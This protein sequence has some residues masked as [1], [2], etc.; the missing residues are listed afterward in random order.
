M[1][2]SAFSGGPSLLVPV[3]TPFNEGLE[4]DAGLF[5]ERCAQLLEEGAHG[6]AVF[7]TTSEANSLS[8]DERMSLLESLVGSGID[9][10]A[11]MPGCGN[12]AIPDAARLVTH[13]V[14]LGCA[15]AL[16]MP[17]FFYRDFSDD[18][19]FAALSE[20]IE[21]VGDDRLR[22]Y[23]YHFPKMSGMPITRA[24]VGRLLA[25]YPKVV[26]GL[27]DSAGVWEDTEAMIAEFPGFEVYSGSESFLLRNL[28]AGGAGCIS[29]TANVNARAIRGLVDGRD[30]D[31]ADGMQE[32]L[33]A[34]RAVFEGC[35]MIPALKAFMAANAG[36]GWAHMRPPL[37]PL[38]EEK[39]RELL[40]RL[41]R[42]DDAD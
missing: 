39:G 14:G 7:G 6:L 40:D 24:V 37:M 41:A 8:L 9:P 31:G 23:L 34:F 10:A 22:M 11:L 3:L 1:V 20:V 33:C 35:P 5:T 15:G 2:S 17:P 36:G 26:A 12:C 13:A 21:R 29:A 27:K 28:R 4:A 38:Q 32:K 42:L 16:V 19:V 18:G 25:R 30:S